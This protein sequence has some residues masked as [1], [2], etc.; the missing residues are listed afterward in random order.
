M[1]FWSKLIIFSK[2]NLCIFNIFFNFSSQTSEFFKKLE[3]FGVFCIFLNYKIFS[4]L[5]ITFFSKNDKNTHHVYLVEKCYFLNSF[6][7]KKFSK[8]RKNRKIA[9]FAKIEKS[10][11]VSDQR[12]FRFSFFAIFFKMRFLAF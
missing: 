4:F 9:F 1:C 3:F 7:F 10:P 8:F 11:V 6:F 2:Y 12:I 5:K